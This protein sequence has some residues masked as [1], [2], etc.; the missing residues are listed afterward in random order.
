[1]LLNVVAGFPQPLRAGE[2]LWRVCTLPWEKRVVLLHK[3]D[4]IFPSLGKEAECQVF[5]GFTSSIPSPHPQPLLQAQ[6][7]LIIIRW[8]HDSLAFDLDCTV[9]AYSVHERW[10]LL[11][12]C[13]TLMIKVASTGAL[14][15]ILRIFDGSADLFPRTW[16]RKDLVTSEITIAIRRYGRDDSRTASLK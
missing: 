3:N 13:F 11:A 10:P 8:T 7:M 4:A 1:M 15:S 12:T 2:G 16:R 6:Q 5:Y 9:I 14:K